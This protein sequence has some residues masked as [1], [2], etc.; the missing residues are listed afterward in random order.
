MA[1][2]FLLSS[3]PLNGEN[4]SSLPAE[5]SVTA[6]AE[7]LDVA[8]DGSGFGILVTD[9]AGLYYGDGCPLVA[10]STLSTT[11]ALGAPGDYSLTWQVI[12]SDGHPTSGKIAFSWNPADGEQLSAGSKTQPV[13][14]ETAI[15]P[16]LPV[17]TS[18][19]TPPPS[20]SAT[21]VPVLAPEEPNNPAA[22]W[23]IGGGIAS[24]LLGIGGMVWLWRTK[25]GPFQNRGL[26]P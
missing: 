17:E 7:L 24:I 21:A 4:V 15:T 20:E 6:N 9:A 8:G 1:H 25:Q 16:L 11:A 14:G 5:F 23:V 2:D 22:P 13:C 12:S 19:A 10:G 26:R 3:T 18:S